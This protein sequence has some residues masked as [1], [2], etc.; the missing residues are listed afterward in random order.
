MGMSPPNAFFCAGSACFLY[1]PYKA[2]RWQC[3]ASSVQKRLQHSAFSPAAL[4]CSILTF[5]EPHIVCHCHFLLTNHSKSRRDGTYDSNTVNN[6]RRET[7]PIFD[8]TSKGSIFRIHTI[9]AN[10]SK[11]NWDFGFIIVH[12]LEDAFGNLATISFWER[13]FGN[14]LKMT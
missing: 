3:S 4:S 11:V 8:L 10:P 9:L 12:V 5:L 7:D 14:I 6:I 13:H 2:R 1:K